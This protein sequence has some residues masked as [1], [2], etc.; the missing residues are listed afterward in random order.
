MTNKYQ[1]WLTAAILVKYLALTPA[2]DGLCRCIGIASST[3][4][5]MNHIWNESTLSI[6]ANISI[7]SC[8]LL[9]VLLYGSD[10]WIL[11]MVNW[12]KFESYAWSRVSNGMTSLR[13]RK[14]ANVPDCWSNQTQPIS[15]LMLTWTFQS[16]SKDARKHP[17]KCCPSSWMLDPSWLQ[18]FGLLE[19][20]ASE[21]T[22]YM[23]E[24][25]ISWQRINTYRGTC[26][27]W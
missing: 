13:T 5:Q 18:A 16:C 22:I 10:T 24:S 4:Y 1:Q 3:M 9:P 12:K 25:N 23:A 20:H 7:N 14:F 27:W 11:T 15:K 26:W 19:T 2:H 21:T 17:N 8:C 6:Q